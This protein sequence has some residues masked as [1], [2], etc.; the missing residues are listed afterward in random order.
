MRKTRVF[1]SECQIPLTKKADIAI[2]LCDK[3]ADSIAETGHNSNISDER[4][5]ELLDECDYEHFK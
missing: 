3:C 5:K 1:C 2:Q 4:R